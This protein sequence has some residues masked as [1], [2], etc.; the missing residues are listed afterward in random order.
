MS[1]RADIIARIDRSMTNQPPT[2]EMLERI[3]ELRGAAKTFA[4]AVASNCPDGRY[5]ALALTHAE[6]SL[7]WAIKAIVLG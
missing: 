4:Y 5:Q 2:P 6:D 1:A 3:S 7:M